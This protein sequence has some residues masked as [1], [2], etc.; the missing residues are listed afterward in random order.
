MLLD[1]KDQTYYY[2]K[3]LGELSS[4]PSTHIDINWD[5]LTDILYIN[6]F[7]YKIKDY[8][9]I[10]IDRV[11]KIYSIFSNNGDNTFIPTYKCIYKN[12]YYYWDCAIKQ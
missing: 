6:D 3:L 8:R 2:L 10:Y 11:W 4:S 1:L 5:G 12:Y 7:S 9:W